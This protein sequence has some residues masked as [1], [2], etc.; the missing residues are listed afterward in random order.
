[1]GPGNQRLYL[2]GA[3]VAQM[4]DALPLDLNSAPPG[5]GRQVS[6]VADPFNGHMDEFRIAHDQFRECGYRQHQGCWSSVGQKRFQPP[7]PR[8]ASKVN[9]KS[10]FGGSG[11]LNDWI[12][13]LEARASTG[14]PG[15]GVSIVSLGPS[16]PDGRRQKV[17]VCS[18]KGAQVRLLV[19]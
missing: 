6:G 10:V 8:S 3:R 1:L 9:S 19:P 11:L 7:S 13:R 5:I 14:H 12:Q 15:C 17:V 16:G 4:S 18:S 2:N